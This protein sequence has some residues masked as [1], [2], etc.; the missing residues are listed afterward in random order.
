MEAKQIQE[1]LQ[2]AV[3]LQAGQQEA[4]AAEIYKRVLEAEPN[5][6]DALHLMALIE[7]QNGRHEKAIKMLAN[8]TKLVP[9]NATFWGNFGVI[10]KHAGKIDTAIK[11]Y[12]RSL[13]L[14]PNLNQ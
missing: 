12:E 3:S 7:S 13:K 6:P 9:N 2:V 11:A 4:K 5:Q 14:N 8:A 10:L 1:Q